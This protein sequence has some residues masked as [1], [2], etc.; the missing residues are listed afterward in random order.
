MEHEREHPHTLER[1]RR[2]DL[3][4]V[5]DDNMALLDIGRFLVISR[6]H[7]DSRTL[8]RMVRRGH[9]VCTRHIVGRGWK[10]IDVVTLTD[11]GQQEAERIALQVREPFSRSQTSHLEH[12]V[13]VYGAYR[14]FAAC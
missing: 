6:S 9:V 7:I 11:R 4:R 3:E 10:R 2:L 14:D 13:A 1:P 12:D 8:D 5:R